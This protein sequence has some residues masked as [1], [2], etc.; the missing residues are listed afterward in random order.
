MSRSNPFLR[1]T[2]CRAQHGGEPPPPG[3]PFDEAAPATSESGADE[4]RSDSTT[5]AASTGF[6]GYVGC[7][8]ERHID[9]LF[10]LL[11]DQV[12]LLLELSH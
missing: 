8:N 6:E 1:F 10:G 2:F 9:A 7:V 4:P 5:A 11:V 12:R 3:N